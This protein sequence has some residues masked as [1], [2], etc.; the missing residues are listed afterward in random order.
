MVVPLLL[1][2]GDV[3]RDQICVLTLSALCRCPCPWLKYLCVSHIAQLLLVCRMR[4]G[5]S[6]VEG[7]LQ[8]LSLVFHFLTD[9][10]I[11][12]LCLSQVGI[13]PIPLFLEFG[14]VFGML[15]PQ[16]LVSSGQVLERLRY[17]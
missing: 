10:V 17:A 11:F 9:T 2:V 14:C 12:A 4:L 15:F 16:V 7:T 3:D 6:M 1:L 5:L 13:I 8:L